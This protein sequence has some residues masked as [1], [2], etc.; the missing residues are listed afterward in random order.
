MR[1]MLLPHLRPLWRGRTTL[2]LGTDPDRAVVVE[3]A[4]PSAARL[5]EL[6]DGGRTEEQLVTAAVRCGV[7]AVLGCHHIRS[8]GSA[9]HVFLDLHVWLDGRMPLTEAHAVSHNVKDLLM[10]RF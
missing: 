8:R 1:P 6:L 7:P 2:Q 5:V 9:D 4:N 3:F 10:Q